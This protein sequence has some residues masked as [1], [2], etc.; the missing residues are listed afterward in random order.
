MDDVGGTTKSCVAAIV[1]RPSAGK[2]TLVNAL[3][4]HKVAIVS[5]IPQTTRNAVRGVLTEGRGQIVFIDTPGFHHSQRRFNQHMRGLVEQTL[6]DVEVVL[7]VVDATRAAGEEEREL[8]SL[9]ALAA[10]DL[11]TIAAVSKGDLATEARRE[12]ARASVAELVPGAPIFQISAQE[13]TGLAELV[14]ELFSVAPV[15]ELLYPDDVYT[16]QPPEFRVAEIIREKAML[17][18]KQELP[19]ALYVEVADMEVRP[20]PG[21]EAQQLWIR[22]FVHVE[23][24]SQKGIVVGSGGTKIKQIRQSAQAEIGA[25]FPYRIHLDLRVKVSSNWRA[26][27]SL[28]GRLIT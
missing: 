22:A 19:H 27:D 25:L 6:A 17:Q 13:G 28:L 4:G 3:C 10:R 11:P 1:G 12:K 23:R 15:G 20:R 24:E 7:Y 18:T 2:S 5:P 14:D 21:K 26:D 8:A 16:D 9:L